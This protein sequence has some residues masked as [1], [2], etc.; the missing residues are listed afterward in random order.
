M[1]NLY[2]SRLNYLS[3]NIWRIEPYHN[4]FI[5]FLNFEKEEESIYSSISNLGILDSNEISA[6]KCL[7][8]R[9][10]ERLLKMKNL[11]LK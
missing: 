5:E 9:D 4:P 11:N 1:K 3:T 2:E 7:I 10:G 8:L 6:E